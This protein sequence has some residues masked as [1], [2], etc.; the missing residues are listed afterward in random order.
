MFVQLQHVTYF[1]DVTLF[2]R[3]K[4]FSQEMEYVLLHQLH[5][6]LLE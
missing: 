5:Y 1:T 3:Y 4:E 2:Q 6:K